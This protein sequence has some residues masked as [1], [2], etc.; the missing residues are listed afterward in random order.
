MKPNSRAFIF[1]AGLAVW[2]APGI[3]AAGNNASPPASEQVSALK[4]DCAASAEA[5][6]ARHAEQPLFERLGGRAGIEAFVEETVRL[7]GENDTIVH[8][9]DGVD[10]ERLVQQVTDFLSA[11]TG[12]Q[13]TYEGQNMVDAHAHMDISDAEFLA[14][15]GDV[16]QAMR[17]E[18]L[19]D[20]EVEEVTCMFVS[21]HGQVVTE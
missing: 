10:R 16:A 14:A 9:M 21:L 19:G 4:Q 5:R 15:G 1:L 6:S 20:A 13:V 17:G 2:L 11:A 18:G 3:G 8:L 12:G 7:H